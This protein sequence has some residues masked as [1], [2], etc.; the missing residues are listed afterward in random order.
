M[1]IE[2]R[3][4]PPRL[5][6]FFAAFCFAAAGI[7]VVGLLGIGATPVAVGLVREP[8]DK[9]AHLATFAVLGGLLAA[10]FGGRRPWLATALALSVGMADEGLQLF[11]PGRQ[12][13]WDDLAA[14]LA[15]AALAAA[16]LW[17]AWGR[18]HLRAERG[19]PQAGNTAS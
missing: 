15:G 8:W 10:G 6:T 7:L 2:T 14:D 18:R 17:F 19:M 13:G 3:R 9:L 16:A 11:H 5:R 12:S 4:S 1:P